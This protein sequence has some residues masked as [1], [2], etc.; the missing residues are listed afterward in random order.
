MRRAKGFT[1]IELLV[2]IAIIAILAAILFPVFA[3]ARE[4]AY[5]T[6]CLSNVKQLCLAT[7]M[8]AS[9]YDS[10]LPATLVREPDGTNIW[11]IDVL[12]P[13]IKNKAV[14]KCPNWPEYTFSYAFNSQFGY[15][16]PGGAGS[17]THIWCPLGRITEPASTLLLGECESTTDYPGP[18][19]P[20]AGFF[21]PGP[22]HPKCCER[23]NGGVNIGFCDGHAKWSSSG[24]II[25]HPEW[26]IPDK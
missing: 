1:L 13:Y 7:L 11:W 3:R 14:V 24:T 10:R 9:D 4:K 22:D 25:A 18:L 5:Q 2:V 23:H 19:H 20:N 26:F 21:Y 17:R 6:S 16:L 15:F 12:D 8:Y